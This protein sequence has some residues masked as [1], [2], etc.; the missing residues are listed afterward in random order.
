MCV[1][2]RQGRQFVFDCYSIPPEFLQFALTA[3]DVTGGA[4]NLTGLFLG[5]VCQILITGGP[6]ARGC[7]EQISYLVIRLVG[8]GQLRR[9][10]RSDVMI[11]RDRRRCGLLVKPRWIA[12]HDADSQYGTNHKSKN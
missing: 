2:G 10:P 3:F 7:L 8:L 4:G 5:G 12:S 9:L 1:A 6:Q 11:Y